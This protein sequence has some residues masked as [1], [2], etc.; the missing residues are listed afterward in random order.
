MF[1]ACP[2][3]MGI[4]PKPPRVPLHPRSLQGFFL[5]PLPVGMVIVGKE[6]GHRMLFQGCAAA[7]GQWGA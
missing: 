2:G 3:D 1:P 5:A 7:W 6:R 4:V